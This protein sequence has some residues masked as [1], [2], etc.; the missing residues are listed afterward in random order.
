MDE[1]IGRSKISEPFTGTKGRMHYSKRAMKG[2]IS[3]VEIS[4]PYCGH[5]KSIR[6]ES[7]LS[8]FCNNVKCAKCKRKIEV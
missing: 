8:P 1:S 7:L 6:N 4:C 5:H 2:V 3:V